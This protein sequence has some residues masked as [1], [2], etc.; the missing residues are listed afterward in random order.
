MLNTGH[1]CR[2]DLTE[3]ERLAV[4]EFSKCL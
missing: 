4:L 1:T 2:D 3:E